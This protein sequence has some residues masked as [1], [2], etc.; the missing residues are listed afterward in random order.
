MS[1]VN[2]KVDGKRILYRP[3]TDSDDR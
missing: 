3:I 2:V 1:K